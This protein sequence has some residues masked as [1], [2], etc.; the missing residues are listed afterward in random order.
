MYINL[1]INAPGLLVLFITALDNVFGFK[2]ALMIT[3]IDYFNK[4]PIVDLL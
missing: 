1:S 2:V 4:F 3:I